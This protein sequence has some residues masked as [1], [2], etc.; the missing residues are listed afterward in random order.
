LQIELATQQ[1]LARQ[2]RS[3]EAENVRLKDDLSIF[4]NLA[5]TEGQEGSLSINRLRIEPEANAPN[6]YRYRMLVAMQ[7]SNKER[8][9]KGTL[10]LALDLQQE[11]HHVMML[12]PLVSDSNSPQYHISFKHFRRLDGTFTVPA[13]ARINSVEVRLLQDGVVKASKSAAL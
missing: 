12:L 9:F 2:V 5:Q 13:G 11:G 7:G 8:E 4:E 10:Q 6:Q 1:Q 3:L